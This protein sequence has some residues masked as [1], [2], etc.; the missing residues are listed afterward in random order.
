MRHLFHS[1]IA[2][3][4][5]W[6][7][8]GCSASTPPK[9]LLESQPHTVRLYE[10]SD[11]AQMAK[12]I[13]E[14]TETL[15]YEIIQVSEQEIIAEMPLVHEK[16]SAQEVLSRGLFDQSLHPTEMVQV[17]ITW[18]VISPQKIRISFSSSQTKQ[19]QV[20]Q[21]GQQFFTQLDQQSYLQGQDLKL[22]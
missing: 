17:T 20:A 1:L 10:T 7:L 16:I 13:Q 5:A 12:S 8:S 6:L 3:I 11:Q 18:Q 4:V 2:C 14:V 9:Q 21:L 19:S 15:G 22:D